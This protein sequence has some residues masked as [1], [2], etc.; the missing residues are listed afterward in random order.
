MASSWLIWPPKECGESSV[1]K[2]KGVVSPQDVDNARYVAMHPDVSS[3]Y[4]VTWFDVCSFPIVD[5]K[6]DGVPEQIWH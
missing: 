5:A 1:S 6:D 2:Q 3:L 4:L